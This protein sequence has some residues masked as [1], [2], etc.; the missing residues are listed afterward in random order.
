M[1]ADTVRHEVGLADT[2]VRSTRY[3]MLNT[4]REM[5]QQT[6]LDIGRQSSVEHI[7]IF[8][9]DRKIFD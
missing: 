5:L 3:A 1:V 9:T 4:D 7:R 6:I 2:V 8:N